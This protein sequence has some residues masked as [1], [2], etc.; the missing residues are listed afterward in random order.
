[1]NNE[2]KN[3][4]INLKN[5][6]PCRSIYSYPDQAGVRQ[7]TT[8]VEVFRH[9][10]FFDFP[11]SP[12]IICAVLM[13]D[14]LKGSY[15]IG[16]NIVDESGNKIIIEKI[17]K[18]DIPNDKISLDFIHTFQNVIFPK[19]GEYFFQLI[20]NNNIIY[21]HDFMAYKI[22]RKEY[23][24]EELKTI[25]DDPDTIKV[26]HCFIQCNCGFSKKY[27]LALN[28]EKQKI[29]EKIPDEN[30]IKCGKCGNDMN[31]AELRANMHFYLGSKIL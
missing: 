15:E 8:C 6:I 19:E 14:I 17:E 7:Y 26:A 2:F 1:M 16:I 5:F 22:Q 30:I 27:S 4:E 25:L 24:S 9:L 31:I 3:N 23:T 29:K 11:S 13:M 12:R 18:L 28:P 10:T 21:R 20:I